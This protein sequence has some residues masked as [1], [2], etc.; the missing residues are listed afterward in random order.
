LDTPPL[1][2]MHRHPNK[3]PLYPVSIEEERLLFS[4]LAAHLA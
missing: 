2:Q 3:R 1:I 4:E